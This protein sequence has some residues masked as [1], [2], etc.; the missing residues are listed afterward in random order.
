M[1]EKEFATTVTACQAIRIGLITLMRDHNW[2]SKFNW[3]NHLIML[4]SF[5]TYLRVKWGCV[6]NPYLS[7]FQEFGG[8]AN[9]ILQS[10]LV[11]L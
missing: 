7:H 6:R 9:L 8:G 1:V 3:K 2:T 10:Y 11:F 4:S 5:K